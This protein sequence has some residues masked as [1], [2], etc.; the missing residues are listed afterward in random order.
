M[1]FRID[2]KQWTIAARDMLL[3]KGFHV[4]TKAMINELGKV[5]SIW[6]RVEEEEASGK[7]I[8]Y[9]YFGPKCLKG[10]ACPTSA[11]I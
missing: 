7:D 2:G 3:L 4:A 8:H 6:R 1:L 9:D 10:F 11:N 5:H